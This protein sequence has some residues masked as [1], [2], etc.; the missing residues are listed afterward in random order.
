MAMLKTHGARFGGRN[1]RQCGTWSAG[2]TLADG[3]ARTAW[4]CAP[5]LKAGCLRLPFAVNSNTSTRV[6]QATPTAIRLPLVCS[7]LSCQ[8]VN[9]PGLHTLCG[10]PLLSGS[11]DCL[12]PVPSI[13]H[14]VPAHRG[15]FDGLLAGKHLLRLCGRPN[16][17]LLL[18]ETSA[19]RMLGRDIRSRVATSCLLQVCMCHMRSVLV[20][21]NVDVEQAHVVR[22][23]ADRPHRCSNHSLIAHQCER[24]TQ[25]GTLDITAVLIVD[26]GEAV[27][28]AQQTN[29][30]P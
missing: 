17:A 8:R 30:R 27:G 14:R 19:A 16:M 15:F 25:S 22:H 13:Q 26:C 3:L 1:R 10:G 28:V 23:R 11:V 5:S 20:V 21:M 18:G 12:A 29:R 7:R 9:D 6:T 24:Q 2:V 4:S